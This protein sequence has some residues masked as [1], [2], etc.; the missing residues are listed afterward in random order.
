MSRDTWLPPFSN[1]GELKAVIRQG[2]LQARS[3]GPWV[4]LVSRYAVL[5]KKLFKIQPGAKNAF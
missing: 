2:R 4:R 3:S 1:A 5:Y